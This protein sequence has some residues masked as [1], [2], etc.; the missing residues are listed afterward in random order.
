MALELSVNVKFAFCF[1]NCLQ[2]FCSAVPNMALELSVNVKFASGYFLT[3]SVESKPVPQPISKIF[4]GA[5]LLICLLRVS[6]T[7]F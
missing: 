2:S 3:I 1:G 6:A 4:S 5:L 7:W